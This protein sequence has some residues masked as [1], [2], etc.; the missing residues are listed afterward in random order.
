MLQHPLK[1]GFQV[2]SSPSPEKQSNTHGRRRLSVV[3]NALLDWKQLWC[4]PKLLRLPHKE[5]DPHPYQ[6]LRAISQ[7][8]DWHRVSLAPQADH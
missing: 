1:V 4:S 2:G 5:D 3:T 7:E 8:L 6:E